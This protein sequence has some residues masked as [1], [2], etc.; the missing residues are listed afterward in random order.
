LKQVH[1]RVFVGTESDCF[2][3]K[4]SWA[5]VHACKS[6]C[7]QSA[8]GYRGSLKPTHPNYLHLQDGQNLYLNI[9]DPSVPL[10]KLGTFQ[11]FLS[12]AD[13]HWKKNENLL[14]HCNLGE[15]RVPT[16]ALVFM[17]KGLKAIPATSYLEARRVFLTI[18]PTY[19]PGQGIQTFMTENWDKF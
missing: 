2:S 17:A 10:F 8:V 15:S 12:F 13:E 7:H 9:I 19:A 6:P 18:Y 3:T 11:V 1:E 5:V 14:I 16:L 4:P